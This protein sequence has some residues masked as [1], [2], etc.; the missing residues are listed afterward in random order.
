[1]SSFV[2]R[3]A[4]AVLRAGGEV[5]RGETGTV[6][7]LIEDLRPYIRLPMPEEHPTR[8]YDRAIKRAVEA[9]KNRPK[10]K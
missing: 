6:I 4:D 2:E 8:S 3:L 1:M 10:Y 7:R 9:N 5:T